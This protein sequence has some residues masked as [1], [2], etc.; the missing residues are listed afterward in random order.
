MKTLRTENI[1]QYNPEIFSDI[2]IH[3]ARFMLKLSGRHDPELFLASAL[4]SRNTG[5]GHVC[6]DLSTEAGKQIPE[7]QGA[8]PVVCPGLSKWIKILMASPVVGVPG[9]FK[10]LILDNSSRLYLH[11]YWE[12]E[13]KLIDELRKRAAVRQD[14][15]MESL[16]R[17]LSRLFPDTENKT[18]AFTVVMKN[19]AVICGGPGT[20]KS[21]TVAKILALLIELAQKDITIKLATPTGKAADRLQAA[22]KK[23]KKKHLQDLCSDQVV[24]AIPDSVSTLHRLLGAVPGSVKQRYN[25]D[26]PLPADVVVVDEASMVALP[27]MTKLFLAT[28]ADAKIIILGDKDQLAS[29]EA[30]AVLG[31]ICCNESVQVF[32]A[33]FCRVFKE[34]TEENL[35]VSRDTV[36]KLYDC[37]SELK[38]NYRFGADSGIGRLSTAVNKGA[39]DSALELLKT[40]KYPDISWLQLPKPGKLGSCLES[41]IL[42]WFGNL[43]KSPGVAEAFKRIELFR[44]LCALRKGPFGVSALNRL[45]EKILADQKMINPASRWYHGRPIIVIRNDYNLKLFNGD[46]GII[47][48]EENSDPRA[49][50]QGQSGTFRDFAP[51]LLPEHET[52]YA[53]TVHKSQGS[54]FENILMILP[55]KESPVLTRELIYTGITRATKSAEI[56]MNNRVFRSAVKKQ[57]VRA[58]GLRNGL[59]NT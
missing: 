51:E 41:R 49:F 54:E 28:R 22:I 5:A 58:S 29:V 24:E 36:P 59:Y 40:E 48:K 3:F 14:F 1:E 45:S 39:G 57:V 23:A 19:F 33:D 50:F 17:G 9:D 38:K 8:D 43:L 34:V 11:K 35:P 21:T 30:G 12:Y 32:S 13:Q 47:W 10:P 7:N 16:S 6:L 31:D 42:A 53:M 15:S 20:G 4:L 52:V 55:E 18:A 44:I 25:E 27:L 46:T 2:D 37:I 26:N 56:W